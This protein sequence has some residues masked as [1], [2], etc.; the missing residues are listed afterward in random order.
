MIKPQKNGDAEMMMRRLA[1]AL[2]FL[3]AVPV[4]AAPKAP[5]VTR[6]SY[7]TTKPGKSAL[8]HAF[9]KTFVPVFEEMKTKNLILDYEFVTPAV[10]SGQDWDIAYLWVCKDMASYG[11]ADD[12]FNAAV[13]KMDGARIDEDFSAAM[14][15]SKHRDEFWRTLAIP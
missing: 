12:Y 6:I 11:Q 2:T 4:L 5:T 10:H 14:D 15:G 3:G 13:S 8:A 9:W 1:L 7:W